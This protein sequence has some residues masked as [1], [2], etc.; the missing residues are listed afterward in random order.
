LIKN[1]NDECEYI[2]E[3]LKDLVKENELYSLEAKDSR[4]Y[5]ESLQ[6][7][8]KKFDEERLEMNFREESEIKQIKQIKQMKDDINSLTL[9]TNQIKM[10]NSKLKDV[11]KQ[12]EDYIQVLLTEKKL[13]HEEIRDLKVSLQNN[14]DNGRIYNIA[15][16]NSN[17]IQN[18]TI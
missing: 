12:K 5:I 2:K 15:N 16:S 8:I 4:N 17:K 14:N 6:K 10:E 13:L 7:E 18:S 3:K 11:K 9:G 1:K